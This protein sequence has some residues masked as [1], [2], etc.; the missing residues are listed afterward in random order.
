MLSIWSEHPSSLYVF[1]FYFH[2]SSQDYTSNLIN[3]TYALHLPWPV[4]E[5][6]AEHHLY[7]FHGARK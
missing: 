5:R 6:K 4:C 1:Y 2:R 7:L 3:H